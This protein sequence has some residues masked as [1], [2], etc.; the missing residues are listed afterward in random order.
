MRRALVHR[1]RKLKH[2]AQY[3]NIYE[4]SNNI[5]RHKWEHAH[6]RETYKDFSLLIKSS[7]PTVTQ[8]LELGLDLSKLVPNFALVEEF[9]QDKAVN[10]SFRTRFSPGLVLVRGLNRFLHIPSLK[11]NI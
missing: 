3:K 10:Q 1:H 11:Q 8:V 2:R 6:E 7:R 5:Y 9:F 4:Q